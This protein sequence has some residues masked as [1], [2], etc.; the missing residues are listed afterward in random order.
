MFPEKFKV[1]AIIKDQETTL[2]RVFPVNLIQAGQALA[3]PGASPDHLPEFRLGTHLFEEHQIDR[4]RHVNSRIHHIHRHHNVRLPLRHLEIVNDRLCI[5]VVADHALGKG[6]AVLRVQLIK[7]LQNKLRMTLILGKNNGLPKAVATRHAD[8]P[9]HEILKYKIHRG[10]VKY[11]P[12]KLF[13][14]NKFG[15]QPVLKKI[16]LIPFLIFPGKIIV[17]NPLLEKFR[18]DLIIVVRHQHMILIHR[19][20][21]IVGIGRD[22]ML[23]LKEVIGIPVHVRL[24]SCGQS[25]QNRIEVFEN[26]PVLFENTAMALIYNNQVKMRGRK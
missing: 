20:L 18:P 13:R 1:S 16:I 7:T 25:H 14:G 4:L 8:P 22:S 10:L 12:V 26:R 11:K 6:S 2:V 5:C 21:I 23:H 24:G 9:L 3:Q 15:H 19:C 17:G